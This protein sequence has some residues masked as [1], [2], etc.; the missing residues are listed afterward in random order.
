MVEPA[1]GFTANGDPVHA[2]THEHLPGDTAYQRF[3]K[4]LAVAI[5]T[6]V[7][8]MTTAYLFTIL[9]LTSLPAVLVATGWFP[10]SAFPAFL[11]R[12]SLIAL[13]AWVAQTFIQLVLLPIIM[14]GQNV[15]NEAADARSAKTFEDVQ[16]LKEMT[17]QIMAQMLSPDDQE[18]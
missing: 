4:R 16:M 10:R 2:K 6:R 11:L 15:Q 14:V 17:S 5:T 9:S 7:G 8:S 3:N 13:V 18:K 12:A 1:H